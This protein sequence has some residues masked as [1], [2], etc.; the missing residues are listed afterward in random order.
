[1]CCFLDDGEDV[2]VEKVAGLNAMALPFGVPLEY[3]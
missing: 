3:L 1:M 2:F